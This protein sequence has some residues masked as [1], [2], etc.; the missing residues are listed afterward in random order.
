MHI[1]QGLF[2][3]NPALPLAEQQSNAR[4]VVGIAQE[5]IYCGKIQIHLAHVGRIKRSG[6]EFHD[7]KATAVEMVKEEVY[8]EVAVADFQEHLP[9]DEGEA[10]GEFQQEA[11]DVVYEGLFDLAFAARISR[12]TGP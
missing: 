11:L 1:P 7:D 2:Y 10:C 8:V 5:V 9:P 3:H 6:F 12:S 4:F